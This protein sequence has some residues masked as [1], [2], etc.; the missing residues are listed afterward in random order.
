M[1]ICTAFWVRCV[2]GAAAPVTG[3]AAA[4]LLL[5]ALLLLL[6]LFTLMALMIVC[7]TCSLLLELGSVPWLVFGVRPG[8]LIEF[9]RRLVCSVLLPPTCTGF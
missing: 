2:G 7:Q 3:F 6:L 1:L 4:A 5:L 9:Q 8:L